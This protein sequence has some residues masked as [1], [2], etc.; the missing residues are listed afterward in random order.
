MTLQDAIERLRTRSPVPLFAAGVWDEGLEHALR[1]ADP[2]ELFPDR[3]VPD[4]RMAACALAGVHLW[5]DAFE[6]A[7]NLCQAIKSPTGSYWHA[8]CHRRE[9][10][11]GEGIESNLRNAKYW[12]RQAG[13]HPL[14]DVVYRS[15]L[16]VLDNAGSGFRW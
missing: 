15:A 6:T 14:F 1:G 4:A 8:L 10:H 9:G 11:A 13:E 2:E 12:F 3:A 7:H 16:S 5:N